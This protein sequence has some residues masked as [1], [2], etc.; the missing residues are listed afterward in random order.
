MEYW[1]N[2]Y[3]ANEVNF[4]ALPSPVLLFQHSIIPVFH[5]SIGAAKSKKFKN[6]WLIA[7]SRK[8]FQSPNDDKRH[9]R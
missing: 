4:R 5:H 1:V 6:L 2:I 3:S 8:T 9:R 7:I